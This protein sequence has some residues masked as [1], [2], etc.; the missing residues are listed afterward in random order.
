MIFNQQDQSASHD[1]LEVWGLSLRI[2]HW[3]LVAVFFTS[4]WAQGRDIRLHMLAG[5]V[6][7]GLL[8]YRL[9]WGFVGEKHAL[10]SSFKP[11]AG[12]I[13]QHFVNLIQL[14]S[15]CYI[16][17]TP[18]GALMIYMLLIVLLSLAMTG[19]ALAGV[20]MGL[21]PL[22]G[23]ACS[24]ETEALIQHIHSWCLDSLLLLISIHVAGVVVESFLQRSNLIV[25]MWNGKKTIKA[26]DEI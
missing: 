7:A 10:F 9:I 12:S 25:A 20:Q 13:K 21:G 17:H 5:G 14:K 24:F 18:I 26:E 11:S 2:Y 22:S 1:E 15:V 19:F 6:I 4:W 8:L 16:G 23:W 3:L